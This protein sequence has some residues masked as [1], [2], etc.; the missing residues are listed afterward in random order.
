MAI[1]DKDKL[2]LDEVPND[3]K[4]S[5]ANVADT[6]SALKS[7]ALIE[8]ATNV[9][10][11]ES[12]TPPRKDSDGSS[13]ETTSSSSTTSDSKSQSVSPNIIRNPSMSL[14]P[15]KSTTSLNTTNLP[16]IPTK[17]LNPIASSDPNAFSKRLNA[18]LKVHSK[19]E[20]DSADEV[21]EEEIEEEINVDELLQSN[22]ED[23]NDSISF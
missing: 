10:A 18:F 13:S 6:V 14:P 8:S 9:K 20:E 5:T 4:K 19:S 15:L 12:K 1:S 2:R 21:E 7:P 11:K 23:D 17:S 22:G 3:P 16:S